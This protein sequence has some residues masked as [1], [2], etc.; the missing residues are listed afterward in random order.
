MDI[1]LRHTFTLSGALKMLFQ[2]PSSTRKREI[3][4]RPG[5]KALVEPGIE[6]AYAIVNFQAD[7]PEEAGGLISNDDQIQQE[8]IYEMDSGELTG[9][10]KNNDGS[11]HV[12]STL[13]ASGM[14]TQQQHDRLQA[15]WQVSSAY[16]RPIAGT[17]N[18]PPVQS[19]HQG[20]PSYELSSEG[21]SSS[22]VAPWCGGAPNRTE[23]QERISTQTIIVK[24]A[25]E[26]LTSLDS[27]KDSCPFS[28][29]S[30]KVN[31]S[32]EM[33]IELATAAPAKRLGTEKDKKDPNV[34]TCDSIMESTFDRANSPQGHIC[35]SSFCWPYGS[36][37]MP[38]SI[39][40]L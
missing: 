22:G 1:P 16:V 37:A 8:Q 18:K 24:V 12:L 10:A 25:K 9:E 23:L 32:L 27:G 2:T 19:P 11:L 36:W 20:I 6:D 28:I 4:N 5:D 33:A 35:C 14:S 26:D 21:S 40:S 7:R 38:S 30:S 34:D 39:S 17:T 29:G 15:F 31:V 3:H 13:Q